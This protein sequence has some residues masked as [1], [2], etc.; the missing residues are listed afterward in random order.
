MARDNTKA[1]RIILELLHCGDGSLSKYKIAKETETNI[2]WTVTLL[3][4]LE[5]KKLIQGT[6]I[7]SL[8]KLIAYYLSFKQKEKFFDFHLPQAEEYLR[9]THRTYALTTYAAENLKSHHLFPFRIDVYIKEEDLEKW[10]KELFQKGLVGKG[11]LRLIIVSDTYIFKFT[12]KIQGLFVVS[13]PLLLI[14]LKKEGGVC[15]EAY[16]YLV[17]KYVSL[18]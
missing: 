12:Q 2:S 3:R 6:K 17:K 18:K 7:L 15:L 13:V 10:K 9:Q 5:E 14:S 11:N 4:K 1:K 16:T 8:D